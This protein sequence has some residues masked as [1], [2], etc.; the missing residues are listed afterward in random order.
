ML[1]KELI[2][3]LENNPLSIAEISEIT[4]TKFKDAENDIVHLKKSLKHLNYRL[5]VFPAQCE[6]CGFKFKEE[7]LHRP[8]KCP[9]CKEKRVTEPKISVKKTE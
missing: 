5:V 6:N 2:E 8:G 7:K 1:R 3:L 4:E 9:V